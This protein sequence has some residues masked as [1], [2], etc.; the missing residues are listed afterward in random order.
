[1]KTLKND[2]CMSFVDVPIPNC[3]HSLN[4][5][6]KYAFYHPVSTAK[7]NSE[8][9]PMLAL[10]KQ[11]LSPELFSACRVLQLSKNELEY[12]EKNPKKLNQQQ[13]Q[14]KPKP[15]KK[16]TKKPTKNTKLAFICIPVCDSKLWFWQRMKLRRPVSIEWLN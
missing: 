9:F 13:Q 10:E 16:I 8:S 15:E 12:N 14:Q 4:T 1:M 3:I 11:S 6:L 7:Q 2:I 5:L